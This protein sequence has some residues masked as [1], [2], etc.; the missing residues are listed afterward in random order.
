MEFLPAKFYMGAYTDSVDMKLNYPGFR[1]QTISNITYEAAKEFCLWLTQ[2]YEGLEYRLPE[3]LE[4]IALNN[5]E[6][7]SIA[8]YGD[9]TAEGEAEGFITEIQYEKMDVPSTQINMFD[10]VSDKHKTGQ[11]DFVIPDE[12]FNKAFNIDTMLIDISPGKSIKSKIVERNL[13][14]THLPSPKVS[15]RYVIEIVE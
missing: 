9:L 12:V 4:L 6:M 8:E 1:Y 14:G 2:K 15:F 3:R 5:F 13:R 10:T 11:Y 7:E